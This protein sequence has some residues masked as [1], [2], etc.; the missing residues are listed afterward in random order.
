M[1]PEVFIIGLWRFECERVFADRLISNK[2]K[3]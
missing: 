2:D 3:E 1:K